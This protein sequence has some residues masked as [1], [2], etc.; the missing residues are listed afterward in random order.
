MSITHWP[1]NRRK[2][3]RGLPKSNSRALPGPGTRR[4][5]FEVLETRA[6][7]DVGGGPLPGLDAAGKKRGQVRM[8]LSNVTSFMCKFYGV[9]CEVHSSVSA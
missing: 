9:L 1:A 6:L 5:R 8:A 4:L 7:L 2:L 3:H